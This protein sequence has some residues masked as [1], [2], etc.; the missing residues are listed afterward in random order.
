VVGATGNG[1]PVVA[2]RVRRQPR[3][4]GR[5]GGRDGGRGVT[6]GPVGETATKA[7]GSAVAEV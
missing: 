5:P 7:H 4:G 1:G 3:H 2:T 6:G